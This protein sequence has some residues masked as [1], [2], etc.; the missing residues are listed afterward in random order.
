MPDSINEHDQQKYLVR[1]MNDELQE[2]ILNVATFL[3]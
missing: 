2:N 3:F 1:I